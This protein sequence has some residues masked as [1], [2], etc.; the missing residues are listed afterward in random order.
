MKKLLSL[1]FIVPFLSFGQC[2]D[3]DFD[4]DGICDEIDDCIGTW[5]ADITTGNCDQFT[6]QGAD[7]CNSYSGCEWTSY[8]NSIT[9]SNSNDCVGNYE[10]DNGYCD[11]QDSTYVPDPG[12]EQRLIDL[13]YDDVLDGHVLTNN[14]DTLTFLDLSW[15]P[16]STDSQISNLIG[17]QDFQSLQQLFCDKN[18]IDTI[19]VSQNFQLEVL[20]FHTSITQTLIVASNNNLKDLYCHNTPI[21]ELNLNQLIWLESLNISGTLI[22]ELNLINNSNLK[23]LTIG[24]AFCEVDDIISMPIDVE[25]LPCDNL[26]N[27]SIDLSFNNSLENL[28][29]YPGNISEINLLNNPNLISLSIQGNFISNLDLSENTL[30]TQLSL[31][32]LPDLEC[33][34]L[35]S[36][37]LLYNLVLGSTGITVLDFSQDQV[38]PMMIDLVYQS[39]ECLQ[40]GDNIELIYGMIKAGVLNWDDQINISFDCDFP[41]E[42]ENYNN[43]VSEN[44]KTESL[45]KTIDILGRENNNKGFQLHIYDDG[46]VEKKYLIK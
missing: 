35:S 38:Y 41:L 22:T 9:Y 20:S 34:D 42:C 4:D 29:I 23:S 26:L 3:G 45:I 16:S 27:G 8:W 6:S 28:T 39:I 17:I 32:N 24:G 11:G 18:L 37:V 15:N 46:S 33:L 14:I 1:L 40:V 13:G 21:V 12:F 36:T 31:I 7:V 2:I 10:I 19:D 30:L 44:I 25:N 43:S 5:I